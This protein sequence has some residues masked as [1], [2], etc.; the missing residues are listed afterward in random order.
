MGTLAA[1]L[2]LLAGAVGVAGGVTHGYTQNQ[3]NE[4][5][6]NL[7]KELREQFP[8]LTEY[9]I[10]A[11]IGQYGDSYNDLGRW[12]TTDAS[13]KEALWNSLSKLD[14]AKEEL[15]ARPEDLTLEQLNEIENQASGE[16][17]AENRQL[18]DLYN[19]VN[20]QSTDLLN[21]QMLE[22]QQAFTDYRNQILTNN[23]MQQ[24]AIA[25]STRYELQR[26]QRN[27]IIRGASAAQRLV[28]N[29][30]T[31]LGMQAKAAQQSLD[32]S[33]ALA[34]QLLAHRQAQAGLRSDYINNMNQNAMNRANTLRGST[35]RKANYAQ[36][37]LDNALNKNQYAQDAWNNR[38][39]DY[40]SGDSVG[41]GIY[42]RQYGSN[43]N[44]NNNNG[45]Y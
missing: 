39:A 15:G 6:K 34:Q 18:L 28:A 11:L 1:I 41:E 40:F 10:D 8:N 3:V 43:T 9:E 2:L 24:Q 26:S 20:N 42:R 7:K 38:V 13:E 31:Q 5:N 36:S 37:R 35:E 29:I 23:A 33:N 16:I 14:S 27:A 25:G 44:R 12:F 19:Q 22:N 17:D 45:G 4:N 30:N 21:Q 32:T